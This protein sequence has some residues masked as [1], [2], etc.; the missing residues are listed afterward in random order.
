MALSAKDKE[1]LKGVH[2]DLVRVITVAAQS[3]PKFIVLEGI[4]SIDQ[5]REYVKSGA[6]WTMNSR[7]LTGHAVD[8]APVDPESGKAS[9]SWPLYYPLAKHMKAI[10]KQQGVPI[11]WGGDW[12][13]HKDG[14]H[15]Q[16]P[17][18]KYPATVDVEEVAK[19]PPA[20]D[21]PKSL[22]KSRTIIGA[23]SAAAGASAI[24]VE[25]LDKMEQ[26][27]THFNAGSWFAVVIGIAILLGAGLSIFA[28][29]DEAGRPLP[30]GD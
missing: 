6:S 30:W 3:G 17:W 28:K 25:N 20:T 1:R 8:I 24:I 21:K 15:W 5:Q 10:A 7:H 4:R 27:N 16:L 23:G 2:P 12:T 19:D 14:P 22:I 18:K 29:W 13:K 9:F 11:E 26:A